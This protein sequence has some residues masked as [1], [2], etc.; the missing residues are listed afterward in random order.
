MIGD[1]GNVWLQMPLQFAFE[2]I[3]FDQN[4]VLQQFGDIPT[5]LKT[6]FSKDKSGP[7]GATLRTIIPAR[8]VFSTMAFLTTIEPRAPGPPGPPGPS[9]L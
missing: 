4:N 7:V 6:M 9:I 3:L 2:H 8:A 5:F 1:V